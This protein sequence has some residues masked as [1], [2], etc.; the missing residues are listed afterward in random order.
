MRKVV[1]GF[2]D[3]KEVHTISAGEVIG[4]PYGFDTNACIYEEDCESCH[5]RIKEVFDP[6]DSVKVEL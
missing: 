1:C 2:N 3:R 4:C 6:N 5:H